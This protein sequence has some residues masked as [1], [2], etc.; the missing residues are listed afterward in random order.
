MNASH[1]TKARALALTETLSMAIKSLWNNRLRTGLT[2]LGMIIG[3]AAVIAITSIGQGV[4]KATEQQLLGLG[5]DIVQVQAGESQ[6]GAVRQGTGTAT[7]LTWE[8]AQAIQAQVS[9]AQAVSA[10]LQQVTQVTSAQ[11]NTATTIIGTDIDYPIVRNMQIQ[12]GRFFDQMEI[13]AAAA[14]AVLGPSLRDQ[15]FGSTSNAIG[16]KIRIQQQSYTVIGVMQP[17]GSQGPFNPDEQVYIPLTNMSA[18]II[19]N[20]ALSGI[21]VRGIDVKLRNQDQIDAV[22]FQITNLLR[23]RHDIFPPAAD[24]FRLT[25]QADVVNTL[26]TIIGLFTIMVVAV[27]AISLVVGGIGIANIML[28]SVV[29][30]TR[31]IG[32]RKAIGA[33]D[34]AVLNQFLTEAITLALLGGGIGVGVGL[35]LAML[36]AALFQFPLV[37]SF[38][39]IMLSFGVSFLVGLLAGVVPARNAARLDP[40]AALRSE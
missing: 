4:Q 12:S 13:D 17:K 34:T 36:A 9:E 38:W 27:A 15:L 6:T 32:I 35:M 29:E 23:V 33:T 19:G 21:A 39:A 8:D 18:R 14:V 26:T 2:M 30:R 20:N 22:E 5:A 31:E 3:I 28:V 16:D 37:L 25:N 24:D 1:P 11:D 7:T 10:Y 40:I